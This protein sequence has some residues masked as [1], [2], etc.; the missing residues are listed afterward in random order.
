[1]RP[2]FAKLSALTVAVVIATTLAS[3]SEQGRFEKTLQVSGAADLQVFT[4]SG[5]VTIRSG[6]AGSI[7]ITGRIHVGDRWFS[8]GRKNE[9]EEIEK[10]PPIQ[11]S[12]NNIRIDY[13]NHQNISV[14]YEIT[15]P[16]DTRIRAKSGSGDQT[17]EGMQA[18]VDIETGS[19][20][21]RLSDLAGDIR[22]HT[23]SGNVQARGASGP[24]EARAGS[25]D[26]KIEEK[27]KGDVRLETGSGNIE[28]RGVDGGLR[29]NTGSGN[30]R[31]DGVPANNWSV[32][33]GSGNA[34]LR[35]PQEA[36]FDVDV[37]TSSG[38]VVV[39]HPVT[40]TVQG[41]VED[42]RKSIRGKVRGG[43]PEI[44]VHTGSG[45][46]HVD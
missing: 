14:D 21:V 29:A 16:P 35:L 24:F 41:R 3:A 11:Q 20:D 44:S 22:I 34:E 46:V 9:V 15:A 27:S 37:S 6:P 45:D 38:S 28:A 19:G 32:K 23:G 5:D 42:S 39:N 18:G 1:M 8:G 13:V 31:I 4:R 25:G 10:N 43:G 7:A 30:V 12:G 2:G 26:I 36:A 40:T 17:I 33:T